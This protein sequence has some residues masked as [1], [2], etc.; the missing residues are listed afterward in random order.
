MAATTQHQHLTAA[1]LTRGYVRPAKRASTKYDEFVS[2]PECRSLLKHTADGSVLKHRIL[3]GRGGSFRY[4][5]TTVASSVPFS[6]RMK[7]R[8]LAEADRSS[9]K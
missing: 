2:T 3:L 1:L 4:T 6:A 5:T 8:L 9:S 7:G